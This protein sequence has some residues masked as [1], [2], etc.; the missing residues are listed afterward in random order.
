MPRAGRGR[1]PRPARM[2]IALLVLE[3]AVFFVSTVPGVRAESGFD[4]LFDGWLQGAGYVT[5]AVVAAY[6]PLASAVDRPVWAWLAAGLGA[7]ALGFV[8]FLVYVRRQDPLPY[9][10]IAD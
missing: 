10:S 6:R 9:P 7:R 4:P 8:L 5:A 3:V 1:P 2:L